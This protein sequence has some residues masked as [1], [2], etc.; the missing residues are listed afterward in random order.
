MPLLRSERWQ[1]P[2]DEREFEAYMRRLDAYFASMDMPLV[3]RQ[4]AAIAEACFDLGE[5]RPV[6]RLREPTPGVYRA[7]D[8]L[9]RVIRWYE[10]RYGDSLKIAEWNPPSM[11]LL[12]G[13]LWRVLYPVITG[14]ALFFARDAETGP[15][16]L[17]TSAGVLLL[18]KNAA[19]RSDDAI[20]RFDVLEFVK[21]FPK[22]ARDLLVEGELP[23]IFT[24]LCRNRIYGHAVVMARHHKY[25]KEALGDI[26]ASVDFL[27]KRPPQTGSSKWAALQAVEKSLKSYL[28]H[29]GAKYPRG[30]PHAHDLFYLA[31]LV[32][33]SAGPILSE[34]LLDEI[35]CAPAVRYDRSGVDRNEAARAH[36]AA[37]ECSAILSLANQRAHPTKP[38]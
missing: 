15:A 11:I 33:K 13:E 16:V 6:P 2:N 4:L 20:R 23:G 3:T 32:A 25:M 31:G 34:Q 18:P 35:Q 37:L 30:G 14:P 38:A 10:D 24:L 12:R 1:L 7:D 29:G 9:L 27:L 21:E 8:F 26:T 22:S 19:E 36:H 17:Y 28:E 5:N